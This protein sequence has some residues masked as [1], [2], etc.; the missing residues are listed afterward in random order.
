MLRLILLENHLESHQNINYQC[1][2]VLFEE[3]VQRTPDKIAVVY[4]QE[5][6]TYRQL[7]NRANQLANYLKSLGVK[8]ETT[9]T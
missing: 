2:H 5:H 9:S 8:P 7:N 4:K 1:V 3:Q 6:L